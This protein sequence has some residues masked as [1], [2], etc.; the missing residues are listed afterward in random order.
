MPEDH[1]GSSS[2]SAMHSVSDYYSAVQLRA[3]RWS[4]LRGVVDGL[5]HL[6]PED[7]GAAR[8]A[9][10]AEEL[11]EALGPIEMYWAFPGLAAF[12]HMRRQL[13]HWNW[14]DLAFS[15][16]RVVRALAS[17]AYRRR[18]TDTLSGLIAHSP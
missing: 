14:E 12:D 2:H 1:P 3:D 6:G 8:L 11:F 13:D 7:A 10:R 16:R 4:A 18:L 5:A 17:G 9:R 15:A